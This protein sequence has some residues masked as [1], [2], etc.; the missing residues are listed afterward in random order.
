M[1]PNRGIDEKGSSSNSRP[2]NSG[3]ANKYAYKDNYMG[4]NPMTHT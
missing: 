3:E 2:K 1:M 4:K